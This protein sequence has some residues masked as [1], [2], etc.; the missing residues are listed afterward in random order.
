MRRRTPPVRGVEDGR[1]A[2][3][4]GREVLQSDL[5]GLVEQSPL[6]RYLGVHLRHVQALDAV[7]DLLQARRGQRT[8]LGED[9]HALPEGHEGR[10]RGDAGGTGQSVLG[11]GVDLREDDV[12]VLLGGCGEDRRERSAGS[13]PG[14]PEVD[15]HD[16]VAGDDRVAVGGGEVTGGHGSLHGVAGRCRLGVCQLAAAWLC[17]HAV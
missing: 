7:D 8:G 10:D 3:P 6:G 14:G 12:G 2:V 1:C 5:P 11:L 16:V 15:E 13:A 17:A 9:E 4:R